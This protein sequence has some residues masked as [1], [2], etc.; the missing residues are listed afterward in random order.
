MVWFLWLERPR[1]LGGS[2]GGGGAPPPLLMLMSSVAALAP[3]ML[4]GGLCTLM[5]LALLALRCG[6]P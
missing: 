5:Q 2:E 4:S 6:R 1:R 3:P